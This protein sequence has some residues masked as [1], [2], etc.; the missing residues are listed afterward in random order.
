MKFNLKQ[1]LYTA[2]FYLIVSDA[3]AQKNNHS[4]AGKNILYYFYSA[5]SNFVGV[6]DHL[7]K[8]IIPAT[9]HAGFNYDFTQ[10]INDPVIEFYDTSAG[11]SRKDAPAIP[12]GEVYSREGKFLYYPQLFD[13]GPDYYA[14]GLRRY[15]DGDKMGF[16]DQYGNK[17][18]AAQWSFVD[19]F[20]YG[21]SQAY[22]GKWKRNYEKGGEHWTIAPDS[23]DAGSHVINR[24]GEKV[25]PLVKQQNPKDYLSD[26]SYYP[27]PFSYTAKEQK[28]TDQLNSL[29]VLNRIF[30]LRYSD[31]KDLPKLQFEITERP[32]QRFPYYILQ[33]YGNQKI[34]EDYKFLV[35]EDGKRIF[36]YSFYVS[37]EHTSLR[38]FIISK[39]VESK[40]YI[41]N[42]PNAPN[43]FDVK[44]HLREWKNK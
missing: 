31:A 29:E 8:I 2:F 10:P 38:K 25:L 28:I 39:L 32:D 24:N 33:G 19:P 40:E 9:H 3:D 44:K 41:R 20:N 6:K 4:K 16:A 11:S 12:M 1:L 36:H 22:T 27:Y 7:G 42:H 17:V 13:N 21:Y 37:E 18:I 34:D 14:E 30:Q 23:E 26:G 15:V 35:T 43:R 5:D